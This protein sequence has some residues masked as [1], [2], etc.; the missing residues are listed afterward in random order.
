MNGY[1]NTGLEL[2]GHSRGGMTLGNMLYSFK[3]KGVHGIAD[4]TTI[5][6]FGPAYNA[7][8][9]ANTLNYVSDGKQDYVNL[10]NHKYDFVGGVIGGNPAT[11]SKV[12]A[13]SNWWKETWKIFTTYPSVHACYGNA[14]LACRRA[15]GNSYKH[16]Q[17]IYSNKSGRKK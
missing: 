8:D 11:F 15:Y 10:E 16:R 7:Q 3:Q 12:L 17:K 5:N 6:L 13:G 4:N 1:G 14:D 2:Y 9:M